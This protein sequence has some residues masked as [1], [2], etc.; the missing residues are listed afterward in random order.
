MSRFDRQLILPGFGATGQERLSQSRVLVVGAGGLGCP[1]L[2]YLAA[3]GVGVIGIVDGDTVAYSNLNRQ[4]LFGVGDVGRHKA[5]VAA[6]RL[7][8]QYPDIK[9]EKWLTFLSAENALDIISRYDLIVDGSDNFP[10][11]YLVNDACMLLK[12][13][14]VLGAVYQYEGQVAVFHAGSSPVSYRDLYPVPPRG[15]EVPNCNEAGVLGVLP[16][17]VGTM[18]AAEAIKLLSGIGQLSVNRV[19]L[20]NMRTSDW[21][22]VE[23]TPHPDAQAM[24]PPNETAFKNMHYD[25][26]CGKASIL[27]WEAALSCLAENPQALVIDIRE[28]EEFPNWNDPRSLRIPMSLLQQNPDMLDSDRELLFCCR[29]GVRSIHLARAFEVRPRT[30][31]VFSIEGGFLH[32]D[33]PLNRHTTDYGT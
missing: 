5:T 4:V 14:L 17:I 1:A 23:I 20:F 31:Q 18:Q 27:S 8:H 12:K 26:A 29:S 2:L 16:G 3:A 9:V 22:P 19:W 13:P 32:P 30:A 21:Y 15:R 25:G 6:E 7:E 28:Q 24:H 11:R 10:T 33:S